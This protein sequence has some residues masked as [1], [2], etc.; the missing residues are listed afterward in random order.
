M[1][2]RGER[3]Q[4]AAEYLGVLLV[5]AAVISGV[6][7]TSIGGEIGARMHELVCKI[8]GTECAGEGGSSSTRDALDERA[9][10]LDEWAGA[11]GDRFRDLLDE[12]DAAN[13]RGDVEEA[14]RILDLLELY[15][16]LADGP[17]GPDIDA[18]IGSSDAAFEDL[19]AEG[20]TYQEGGKYNRRYF[21]LDPAPGEG[22]LVY[23]YYIPFESS[24]FLKGD[25]RGVADPLLGEYGQDRSRITVIID[26]ETGRG[27]VVQTET[28][29]T[30]IGA[31]FCNEPRPITF[32]MDDGWENDSENDATGEGINIDQTNQFEFDADDDSVRLQYDALNSITPLGIS[33]DGTIEINRQADGSYEKGEDTRDDYPAK[34][35]YHYRPGEEPDGIYD[36]K[37]IHPDQVDG[38]LPLDPD[39]ETC[40]PP[41]ADNPFVPDEVPC[42]T[43][44]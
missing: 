42:V 13:A 37:D 5:V 17:R 9:R 15:R 6:A 18:L 24:L 4:T 10:A 29:T 30:G 12:A 21:Q 32:D 23:D 35:I 8:A 31:N 1:S 38:A 20:T 11:H 26:R 39:L 44:D 36:D 25:D 19:L 14:D 27:V 40:T 3:G 7:T 33:V 43:F 34:V 2:L 28:C 16:Q 22:V 41:F